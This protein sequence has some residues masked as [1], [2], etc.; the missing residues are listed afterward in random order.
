MSIS[1]RRTECVCSCRLI[2]EHGTRVIHANNSNGVPL[3]CDAI[4]H[5]QLHSAKLLRDFASEHDLF[6]DVDHGGCP[7]LDWAMRT[8]SDDV[9]KFVLDSLAEKL[10]SV[11]ESRAI[12][13]NYLSPLIEQFPDLIADYLENDK[14]SFEYGRFSVPYTLFEKNGKCPIAMTTDEEL[15]DWT[16]LDSAATKDFWMRNSEEQ[17]TTEIAKTS[18]VHV[19][20]IAKFLC[21]D[22]NCIRFS[23]CSLWKPWKRFCCP[24]NLLGQLAASNLPIR[25]F[26]SES[27]RA[28]SN[29]VFYSLFS[30]FICLLILDTLAAVLFSHVTLIYGLGHGDDDGWEKWLSFSFISATFLISL[31]TLWLVRCSV[32]K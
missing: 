23:Y 32:I 9:A 7:T 24:K 8:R 4:V 19:D 10:L 11:E 14:F 6:V 18:D 25:A 2:A 29:W 1:G 31:F 30:R 26:R 13:T 17:H 28:F 27:F 5:E 22:L 20:V 16:M 15:G 21:I 12:L 3:M